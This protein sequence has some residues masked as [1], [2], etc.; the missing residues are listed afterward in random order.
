MSER[1][2][3]NQGVRRVVTGDDG[4]GNSTVAADST[5]D[6]VTVDLMPGSEFYLL[7]GSDE[8]PTL[9]T[10]GS[11]P[12]TEGYFPP[13]GGFRAI[14]YTLAP[15]TEADADEPDPEAIEEMQEKLP[16][17]LEAME[18]EPETPGMHTSDTI[19]CTYIISGEITCVLDDGE[20][21]VLQ[22]GDF[23]VMNGT[24]HAWKNRSDDP[25]TMMVFSI[26][27]HRE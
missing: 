3:K 1:G 8:I 13:P 16:G 5:V 18:P 21:F 4:E 7:W 26:G 24:R 19:E 15:D 20:E 25:V 22:E 10:D 27:A 23:N 14:M 2:D 12:E 6:P 9:P 17:I 11:K